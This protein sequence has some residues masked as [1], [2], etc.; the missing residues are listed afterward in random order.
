MYAI[1]IFIAISSRSRSSWSLYL[2]KK[3]LAI[4]ECATGFCLA[5]GVVTALNGHLPEPSSSMVSF[6]KLFEPERNCDFPATQGT[7]RQILQIMH[8]FSSKKT[9]ALGIPLSTWDEIFFS[10]PHL[11]LMFPVFLVL[12]T[13]LQCSH[14]HGTFLNWF[15]GWC[16]MSG[17]DFGFTVFGFL[18]FC[19]VFQFL[20]HSL[21]TYLCEQ[22]DWCQSK[23][24]GDCQKLQ[25]LTLECWLCLVVFLIQSIVQRILT[26][27]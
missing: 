3:C 15:T 2:L 20:C 9:P 8:F 11:V 27:R 7:W 24:Q 18:T 17:Y 13:V 4:E 1:F 21:S 12:T 26:S 10:G 22:N 19:H 16:M 14:I 23:F 6:L 25:L 5:R